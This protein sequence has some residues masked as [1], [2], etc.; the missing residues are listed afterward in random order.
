ML[1]VNPPWKIDAALAAML[2]AL[3]NKLAQ[4]PVAA[5]RLRWLR[6]E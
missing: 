2:P 1:I 4:S 6:G 3:C 5:H